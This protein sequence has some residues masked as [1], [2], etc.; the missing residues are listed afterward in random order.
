M[1]STRPLQW[2]LWRKRRQSSPEPGAAIFRGLRISL[3]LWYSGVLAAALVLFGAALYL[4][5]RGMLFASVE[6]DLARRA[7]GLSVQWQL[8][9][10]HSCASPTFGFAPFPPSQEP[11]GRFPSYFLVAC[12]DRQGILLQN[13]ETDQLPQAFLTS[14]LA[15]TARQTG[16]E[17]TD[18]VD[19]GSTVGD[20]YRYAM[21][22]PGT[23]GSSLG[24]VQVGQFIAPQETAI[25]V[26]L[27]LLFILGGGILLGAGL[28]GLFLANR[29]LAPA[30][31]AFARQQRFI[32]DASHELRTPLALVRADAE[33][34]LRGRDHLAADDAAL[35]EDIV[36]EAS[37]MATL[38]TSMLELARLDAGRMHQEREVVDLASVALAV[39]HRVQSLANEMH[40]DVEVENSGATL[41]IGDPIRLEQVVLV[42]L[43]NALKYNRIGGHVTVRTAVLKGQACLEVRD[44]GIGIAA[45][46]L[47]HL[48]ERF[49]RVDKARSR[50]AGGTGLGLAIAHGIA[51]AHGGTLT[52]TSIPDQGTTATLLLPL[53]SRSASLPVL[54]P[55]QP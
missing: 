50:Q 5:V 20:I 29:A 40:I 35:L 49:Y 30:R 32:A 51:V 52:L 36:A 7:R 31:L 38:A 55:A 33:V 27:L 12:F 4:G 42:L 19:G 43:D 23:T 45:E 48:T 39:V 10:Y 25:N 2:S 16:K 11:P 6:H 53:A 13:T 18:I 28:G 17:A 15:A 21:V 26:L 47:P 14:T 1:N 37:H 54:R 46:H 9:P 44:T 3:T 8:N 34:L 24:V 41:V 22:V